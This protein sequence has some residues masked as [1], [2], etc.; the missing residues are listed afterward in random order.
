MRNALK[1][2]NIGLSFGITSAVAIYL[3]Y[4]GGAWV[5]ARLETHP[6]FMLVCVVL[7]IVVSFRVLIRDV[8]G[9]ED[10]EL[11][12]PRKREDEGQDEH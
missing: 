1:Y 12:T 3:G 2:V 11:K 8:L 7:A 6:I 5:D 4:L 9:V 10:D